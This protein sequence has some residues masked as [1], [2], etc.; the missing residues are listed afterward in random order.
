VSVHAVIFDIRRVSAAK[1]CF[2]NNP[3]ERLESLHV[4]IPMKNYPVPAECEES[5]FK[6]S[7]GSRVERGL[8]EHSRLR[9]KT[10]FPMRNNAR[11]QWGGT[12]GAVRWLAVARKIS[13][14]GSG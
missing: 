12:V 6:D 10:R 5:E 3:T 8:S 14:C 4:K 9:I 11:S 7:V 13:K 2:V 1:I